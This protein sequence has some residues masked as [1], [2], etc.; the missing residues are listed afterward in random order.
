M[1][2]RDRMERRAELRREWAAKRSD[3][4]AAAF[5]AASAVASGIPFGQPILVGHHSEARHRSDVAK[6]DAKMAAGVASARMADH[7]EQKA[8]IIE[9][10]LKRTIFS[11]DA[12]AV[13]NLKKRIAARE[14]AV[15]RMKFINKAHAKFLKTGVMP[16][17]LSE[18][19]ADK[20]RNYKPAYSWEPHPYPPY[21][22]AN[23]RNQIATDKKRVTAVAKMA[24]R[25]KEASEASDGVL[26]EGDA[27]VRVTF[28]EKP[29]R[30]VINRLKEAG[31]R[32]GGGGWSGYREQLPDLG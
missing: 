25:A 22:L 31:F 29:D 13:A 12:D 17:G 16:D 27:F 26:I 18:A 5:D 3:K 4:A 23:M 6:I 2:M 21:A 14:Q 10:R 20:V 19:E 28:A 9:G 15:E 32:W 1:T 7:H 8:K 24:E 11:D 30:D